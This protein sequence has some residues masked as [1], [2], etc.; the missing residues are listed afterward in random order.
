MSELIFRCSYSNRPIASGIDLDRGEAD[1][2]R[3]VPIRVHCPHCGFSHDD[4][5]ADGELREAA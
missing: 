2:M 3:A 1:K 4:T 5:V